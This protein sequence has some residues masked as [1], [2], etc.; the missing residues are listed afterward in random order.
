MPQEIGDLCAG[1]AAF[2][3]LCGKS[4]SEIVWR[5]SSDAQTFECSLPH[6]LRARIAPWLFPAKDEATIFTG[7]HQ[8]GFGC[9]GDQYGA[10]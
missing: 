8:N 5:V 3:G 9:V 1:L 4:G 7:R 2:F 6:P 10:G